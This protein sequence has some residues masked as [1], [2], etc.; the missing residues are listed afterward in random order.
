[1]GPAVPRE[2]GGVPLVLE[3]SNNT[4]VWFT[5]VLFLKGNAGLEDGATR[6][7]SERRNCVVGGEQG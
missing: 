6:D 5:I 2:F 1:M 3:W 7:L 4:L